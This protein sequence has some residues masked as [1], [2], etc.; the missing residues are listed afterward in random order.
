MVLET[1]GGETRAGGR[2]TSYESRTRTGVSGVTGGL[3]GTGE[4][5]DKDHS[6][7][8]IG[9]RGTGAGGTRETTIGGTGM[10]TGGTSGRHDRSHTFTTP[11]GNGVGYDKGHTFT[12]TI[13]TSTVTREYVSEP[14]IKESN[15]NF[16]SYMAGPGTGSGIGSGTISGTGTGTGTGTR[17]YT[18]GGDSSATRARVGENV[19]P[20]GEV[21]SGA[22]RYATGGDL[23]SS[24]PTG[25][26]GTPP[27]G[28]DGYGPRTYAIGD[29]ATAARMTGD[30]GTSSYA[31]GVGSSGTGLR[32]SKD[33]FASGSRTGSGGLS[34]LKDTAADLG[35]GAE[36][37]DG[38]RSHIMGD[39]SKATDTGT[40]SYNSGG[41]GSGTYRMS[42]DSPVT[43]TAGESYKRKDLSS[44]ATP[45]HSPS[46]GTRRYTIGG[47]N[48]SI[49]TRR[50][51]SPVDKTS[52]ITRTTSGVTRTIGDL[53]K[54]HEDNR[55]AGSKTSAEGRR[56]SHTGTGDQSSTLSYI[57]DA[58]SAIGLGS[59]SGTAGKDERSYTAG[60][61]TTRTEDKTTL[62]TLK[63]KA[64][65]VAATIGIGSGTDTR[66]GRDEQTYTSGDTP[67]TRTGDPRTFVTGGD[68]TLS[69]MGRDSQTYTTSEDTATARAGDTLSHTK[70]TT[71]IGSGGIGPG[72]GPGYGPDS[73]TARI[74][75]ASGGR[76]ERDAKSDEEYYRRDFT[77][78]DTTGA[79]TRAHA[80]GGD[81]GT[82]TGTTSR[83]YN[84]DSGKGFGS[85]NMGSTTAEDPSS[86][87][88]MGTVA[89]I[90]QAPSY[91][92]GFASGPRSIPGTYSE[93][94]DTPP[95]METRSGAYIPGH[96]NR[97][98][99]TTG[100]Q[101]ASG[102][103]RMGRYT[104]FHPGQATDTSKENQERVEGRAERE[105][106]QTEIERMNR[107]QGE[108]K[109]VGRADLE[110]RESSPKQRR[111]SEIE[112]GRVEG[113]GLRY[114]IGESR[115]T[116]DREA[117]RR[118]KEGE[119]RTVQEYGGRS[120]G[121]VRDDASAK[122]DRIRLDLE[123]ELR[124]T[125]QEAL[126][127]ARGKGTT[128]ETD[129]TSPGQKYSSLVSEGQG[130]IKR[131]RGREDMARI[132]SSDITPPDNRQQARIP[133]D[134][135][136]Q[137]CYD[138]GIAVGEAESLA[139]N[140]AQYSPQ[141]AR[142]DATSSQAQPGKLTREHEP[143][144]L[145]IE[146]RQPKEAGE[147]EVEKAARESSMERH[148]TT[149]LA[150]S[151]SGMRTTMRDSPEYRE[152]KAND[153]GRAITSE[154]EGEERTGSRF[155]E[156]DDEG[157]KK[158][159]LERAADRMGHFLKT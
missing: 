101:D 151:G 81:T 9:S 20:R 72:T 126:R 139:R 78:R 54:S 89:N 29:N 87:S 5:H 33:S 67:G 159:I 6:P 2:A 130:P 11:G 34:Y 132:S 41:A 117:D 113:T 88:T 99:G 131:K 91:S 46:A 64:K 128:R 51:G 68:S 106:E 142:D 125:E 96:E 26:A 150:R 79:R 25:D 4:G 17:M 52:D 92:E 127:I 70:D 80:I 48:Y 58:A 123:Q 138:R 134:F 27:T 156:D 77:T 114:I 14:G 18:A 119:T 32:A 62:G 103:M 16:E 73:T 145:N 133:G 102:K 45:S 137:E 94:H 13:P 12:T 149:D 28:K 122:H 110:R 100:N 147:R 69:K 15:T 30:M 104:I 158:G 155:E 76:I 56:A 108:Q 111:Q 136:T 19:A 50:G 74:T 135:D 57:K 116:G 60:G 152:Q 121:G 85:G 38:E 118:R 153:S 82:S 22:R 93:S 109:R 66:T 146:Q 24:S 71:G 148:R 144:V 129:I 44:G 107:E 105:R 95:T 35:L 112:A 124:D 37:R 47:D 53:S 42:E 75:L 59:G 120:L 39:V 23:P 154:K 7:V 83:G 8:T 140:R 55:R 84:I 97:E 1:T 63:G 61:D 10:G 143:I 36:V 65:D 21:G 141:E 90:A 157:T 98:A 3:A 115:S 43:W 40:T 86:S 49:G 31:K